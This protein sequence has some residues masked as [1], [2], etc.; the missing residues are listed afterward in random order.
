V[1][2]GIGG[3]S[4]WLS[5]DRERHCRV[6]LQT[7]PHDFNSL[8]GLAIT[9]IHNHKQLHLPPPSLLG[10]G[11]GIGMHPYLEEAAACLR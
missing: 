9:L 5:K 11:N 3:Q 6:V 7:H 10:I 2:I 8:K 1:T 4:V